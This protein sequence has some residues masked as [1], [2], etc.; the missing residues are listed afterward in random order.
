[1]ELLLRTTQP[2]LNTNDNQL[3]DK[4]LSKVISIGTEV[5][6]IPADF[7]TSKEGCSSVR[8]TNI[9]YKGSRL[10]QVLQ[11]WDTDGI[12]NENGSL[13]GGSAHDVALQL[14][15]LLQQMTD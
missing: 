4:T 13:F 14:L 8:G 3:P 5:A 10:C 15:Q 6:F 12:L 11:K 2:R 1:M 9:P 7:P